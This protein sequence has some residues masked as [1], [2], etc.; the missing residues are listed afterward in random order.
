MQKLDFCIPKIALLLLINDLYCNQ[1]LI[2]GDR[3]RKPE[4]SSVSLSIDYH[5]LLFTNL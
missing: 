4:K 3:F 5:Y 2:N 1:L